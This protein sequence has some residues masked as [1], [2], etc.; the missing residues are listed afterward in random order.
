VSICA[1]Q[2]Q[3]SASSSVFQARSEG[4]LN[5]SR[6]FSTSSHVE[7]VPGNFVDVQ[8]SNESREQ[9]KSASSSAFQARSEG[10]LREDTFG[11][12][13]GS[14]SSRRSLLLDD[15]PLSIR[16]Q[17]SRSFRVSTEGAG[18]GTDRTAELMCTR[19]R[20]LQVCTANFEGQGTPNH[21]FSS[22]S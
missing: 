16:V 21:D 6:H 4:L 22:S 7:V 17:Q 15:L 11:S 14:S 19:S 3:E 2:Q 8:V 9:Q 1:V 18:E 12:A 13:W 5:N 20:L 10:P